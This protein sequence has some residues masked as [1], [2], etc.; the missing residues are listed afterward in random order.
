MDRIEPKVTRR[1]CPVC[2]FEMAQWVI[3]E[4]K[5]NFDCR[6]K[7]ARLSDYVPIKPPP[8]TPPP[9]KRRVA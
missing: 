9:G 1:M 8:P 5:Y 7:R 4:A 2:A 3:E 6:C